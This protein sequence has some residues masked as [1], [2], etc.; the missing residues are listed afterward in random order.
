[1]IAQRTQQARDR[2]KEAKQMSKAQRETMRVMVQ[3]MGEEMERIEVYRAKIEEMYVCGLVKRAKKAMLAEG[4]E[5][6]HKV[7][8]AQESI[9]IMLKEIE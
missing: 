2:C 9:N 7:R 6:N 8:E 5:V 1:M 4:R 3:E